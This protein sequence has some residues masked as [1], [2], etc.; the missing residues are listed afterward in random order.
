MSIQDRQGNY[1]KY[2]SDGSTPVMVVG[3]LTNIPVERKTKK[4]MTTIINAVSVAPGA[5]STLTP[6]GADGTESEIFV[7]VLVDQQP[8]NLESLNLH[9][10]AASPTN[11]YPQ[12][13]GNTTAFTNPAAPAL[14]LLIGFNPAASGLT[15][16]TTLEGAKALI[17]PYNTDLA[18]KIKNG[19]ATLN[20]TVTVKVI[21][22]WR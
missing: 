3:S 9:V 20:A 13:Q 2:N 8:W 18:I 16:P 22:I 21:R 7:A 5:Y 19:H 10:I 12:Y 11:N 1:Q 4:I 17:I 14:S 15:A 6:V